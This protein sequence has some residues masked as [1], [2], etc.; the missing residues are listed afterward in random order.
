MKETLKRLYG[1]GKLTAEG[2]ANAVIK[3]WITET[4]KKQIMEGR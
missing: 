3:G 2:L 4:E 1:N